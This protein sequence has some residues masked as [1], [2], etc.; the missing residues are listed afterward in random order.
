MPES[1]RNPPLNGLADPVIHTFLALS[2][3]DPG[4]RACDNGP[5]GIIPHQIRRLRAS[6]RAQRLFAA[7][8]A[9]SRSRR[10]PSSPR[11]TR[12][13]RSP[14]PTP[15]ISS[16]RSSSRKSSP[17]PAS[18]RSSAPRSRSISATRRP[19]APRL[20]EQ[21]LAR[22]PIVL[23]A[24]SET[25]Y[26]N[27]MRLVSSLWLDPTEGEEPHIRFERARRR[28]GPHRADR[29]SGGADRPRARRPYG[30]SRARAA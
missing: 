28:R 9:R 10:W 2:P 20:A 30:R 22:A 18:S 13:R 11:P 19:P 26:R 25:G 1:P 24:Q 7:R 16:A 12:C 21:R 8:R 3:L 4:A 17:S 14:S 5:N 6:A 15:T 29:R 27:L 23:L